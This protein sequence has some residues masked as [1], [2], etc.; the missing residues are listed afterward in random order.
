[1]AQR[2]KNHIKAN[3]MIQG[4]LRGGTHKQAYCHSRIQVST[5]A[6]PKK[7]ACE[8]LQRMLAAAKSMIMQEQAWPHVGRPKG[9]VSCVRRLHMSGN[10]RINPGQRH[11][12]CS[13]PYY[14]PVAP[15]SWAIGRHLM[16]S[17]HATS[18]AFQCHDHASMDGLHAAYNAL[19]RCTVPLPF[20][21]AC[22]QCLPLCFAYAQCCLP[23]GLTGCTS[24]PLAAR[25][26]PSR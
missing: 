22:A 19:A 24:A 13:L 5:T 9:K 12:E 23:L 16:R 6:E 18:F 3:T 2:C 26:V 25:R 8:N 4:R 10:A 11:A 15:K 21:N 7:K 14:A 17:A 20:C 1:M